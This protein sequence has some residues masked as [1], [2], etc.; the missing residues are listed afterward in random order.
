M[1]NK[2]PGSQ[3][4]FDNS[5]RL[6]PVNWQQGNTVAQTIDA[7]AALAARYAGATDTVTS[8][9]LLNEPSPFN[10]NPNFLANVK[11]FYESGYGTVRSYNQDTLV[12]IHDAFQGL[13]YWQGYMGPQT[14]YSHVMLDVHLYQIFTEDQIKLNPSEHIVGA[15]SAGRDL[16]TADKWTVV[17]EW[18]GAQT[19]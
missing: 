6:G 9:E 16:S 10:P 7:I 13:G 5:G 11:P 12:V 8:I 17:G 15:C 19:E 2:A 18:S 4:G 14:S 3:N 1:L